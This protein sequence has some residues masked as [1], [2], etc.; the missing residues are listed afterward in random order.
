MCRYAQY[1]YK[2]HLACFDCRKTFKR[3]RLTDINRDATDSV[4]ARCPQCQGLL[5]DMGL[6]FKSPPASDHKAW[7]HL[8]NLYS[9]GITYHSC[10][11]S[12]PGY[13]PASTIELRTMLNERKREYVKN[14]GFWL[15][16]SAPTTRQELASDR[17]RNYVQ[18]GYVVKIAGRK[19]SVIPQ[20]AVAY[21]N[22][23]I[24]ELDQRLGTLP[25]HG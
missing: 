24:S 14:L 25:L 15:N 2:P 3:R 9:A 18:Y 19:G 23:R 1:T 7:Q 20:E 11:C 13:I 5:A 16:K 8:R 22:A 17:E 4:A 10:G 12:G 21:W 6:D